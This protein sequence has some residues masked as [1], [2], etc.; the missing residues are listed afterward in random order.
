MGWVDSQGVSLR[1]NQLKFLT[2][3]EYKL[4]FLK[5][6]EDVEVCHQAVVL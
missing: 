4:P 5:A 6:F 3:L 2:S 1:G